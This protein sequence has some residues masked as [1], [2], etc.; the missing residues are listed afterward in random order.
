MQPG[1]LKQYFHQHVDHQHVDVSRRDFVKSGFVAGVAAGVAA[2][3]AGSAE[4]AEAQ[5]YINPLGGQWWPSS[6][7]AQ[8]VRG[9]NNRITPAK[10]VEAARLIKT[11]KVY[12]L[13][14][15]LEK[16]IPLFGERLGAHVV[17]PGTPTGGRSASTTSTI[18][19]SYSWERSARSGLSSTVS[20][21]S[22]WSP[23]TARS[24]TTTA[25]RRTR[26]AAPTA[27]RSSVSNT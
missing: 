8:D 19:T 14:R 12:Q 2:G 25:C 24:V 18:T 23:A 22:A 3:A 27:S 17:L 9:A 26:S 15:L 20:A 11:G 7:G 13:G 4:Q 21:I 10:V 1:W 16:G 5:T 6:W